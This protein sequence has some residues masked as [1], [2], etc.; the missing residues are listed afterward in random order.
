MSKYDSLWI[1]ILNINEETFILT[2][3]EIQN[4]T[5]F[6]IDHSFLSYKKELLEYGYEV[7]KISTKQKK[8]LFKKIQSN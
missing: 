4:I 6:E 3:E 2:F 1:Y 7:A 5:G 8:V